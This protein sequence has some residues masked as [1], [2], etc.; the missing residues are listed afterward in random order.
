MSSHEIHSQISMM[1]V[2]NDCN[3]LL[4]RNTKT[5]YQQMLNAFTRIQLTNF[6]NI[7]FTQRDFLCLP[8]LGPRCIY[9]KGSK[10]KY[11]KLSPFVNRLILDL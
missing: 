2:S 10:A 6:G 4:A 8:P 7:I 9:L 1:M 11:C 3:S 5:K